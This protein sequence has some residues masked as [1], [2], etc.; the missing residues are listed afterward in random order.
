MAEKD[1][2][3][4]ALE[5]TKF[6]IAIDTALIAFVTGTSFLATIHSGWERCAITI[7]LTMLGLSLCAGLV[8]YMRA[9]TM[10][11]SANYDLADK[12]LR[13]P[14]IINV[15]CFGIGALGVGTL[16]IF[17]LILKASEK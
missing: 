11:S 9:A 1:G 13:F 6:V 12:H 10:F 7:V 4:H 5:F 3:Q 2:L 17:D 14:G 16:A 8:V 15:L